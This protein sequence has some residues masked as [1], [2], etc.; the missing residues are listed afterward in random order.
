MKSR[1]GCPNMHI[2][3]GN[4]VSLS[5]VFLYCRIDRWNWSVLSSPIGL[6]LPVIRRLTVFQ[7]RHSGVARGGGTGAMAH[8]QTFGKCIFLQL[9]YVV[10]FFECV[11]DQ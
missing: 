6:V 11:S 2:A 4:L 5:G 1:I 8:P 7:G 9:I 10:T 3:G